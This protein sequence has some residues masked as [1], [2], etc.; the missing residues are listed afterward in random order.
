M[1]LE[2]KRS[3]FFTFRHT[4]SCRR[5][6]SRPMKRNHHSSP[7]RKLRCAMD[8]FQPRWKTDCRYEQR[9]GGQTVK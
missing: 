9:D 4:Q 6:F 1:S 7:P 5:N 2:I 8:E 3:L